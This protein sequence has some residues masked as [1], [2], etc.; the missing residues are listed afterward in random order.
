MKLCLSHQPLD[1]IIFSTVYMF[2][3]LKEGNTPVHLA[4]PR[5]AENLAALVAAGANVH[6]TNKVLKINAPFD[7]PM[8]Y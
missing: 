4:A 6:V 5:S 2:F 7:I 8:N 1:E 3:N